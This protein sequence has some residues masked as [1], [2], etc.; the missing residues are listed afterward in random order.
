[1]ALTMKTFGRLIN[2]VASQFGMLSPTMIEDLHEVAT[3]IAVIPETA[4]MLRSHVDLDP[5]FKA[6][7]NPNDKIEAIKQ[8]RAVTGQGLKES[9]DAVESIM[10]K[11]KVKKEN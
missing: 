5:L 3:E 9:K 6:L 2:L 10:F 8:Y 11:L 1:M 4:A 7:L